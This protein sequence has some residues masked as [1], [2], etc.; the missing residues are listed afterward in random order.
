MA[1]EKKAGWSTKKKVIVG[2]II[3]IVILLAVWFFTRA[4]GNQYAGG[5]TLKKIKAGNFGPWV[6]WPADKTAVDAEFAKLDSTPFATAPNDW[7]KGII[8]GAAWC[9]GMN[10]AYSKANLNEF[11]TDIQ[12][13]VGNASL[14]KPHWEVTT[15]SFLNA[16]SS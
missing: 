5:D 6:E 1:E 13:Y 11:K 15:G 7:P 10:I 16:A 3:L 8:Y 12:K 4:K 14:R 9:K 2:A